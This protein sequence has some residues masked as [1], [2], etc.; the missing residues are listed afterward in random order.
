[1]VNTRIE[2]VN[3]KPVFRTGIAEDL[4]KKKRR[5][6]LEVERRELIMTI[7]HAAGA[8]GLREDIGHATGIAP[9]TC[10]IC[11][12]LRM[13]PLA[14]SMARYAGSHLELSRALTNGE[15]HLAAAGNELWLCEQSFEAFKETRR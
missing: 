4:M 10:L 6:S 5:L 3:P 14:E 2:N 15:I 11:G 8:G 7:R 13:L 12:C 9:A 1:M